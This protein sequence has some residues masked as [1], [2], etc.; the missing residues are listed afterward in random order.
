MCSCGSKDGEYV[1]ALC[2]SC[3]GPH[4]FIDGHCDLQTAGAIAPFPFS[5]MCSERNAS[6]FRRRVTLVRRRRFAKIKVT[7]VV[8]ALQERREMKVVP[9]APIQP[10]T[11]QLAQC[12]S[13]LQRQHRCLL[14]SIVVDQCN[15]A[16]TDQGYASG[17]MMITR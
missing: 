2:T 9:T 5:M 3:C 10:P 14:D 6:A 1:G 16:C 15:N 4:V 12:S 11:L 7:L 8:R 17:V 13:S